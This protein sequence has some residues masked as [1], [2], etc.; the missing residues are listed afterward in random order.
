V[1]R[2]ESHGRVPTCRAAG[3]ARDMAPPPR[4]RR[5]DAALTT[6]L[7]AGVACLAAPAAG[8]EPVADVAGLL[9]VSWTLR[10]SDVTFTATAKQP[11]GCAATSLHPRCRGHCAWL[12]TAPCSPRRGS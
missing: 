6:L 9:R 10:A 12:H 5:R 3:L 8:A 2:R 4:R 1:Y 7:L 11:A